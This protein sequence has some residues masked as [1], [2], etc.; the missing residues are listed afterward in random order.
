[1]YVLIHCLLKFLNYFLYL[2]IY[3]YDILLNFNKDL[4]DENG[5]PGG[6]LFPFALYL[7]ELQRK[8]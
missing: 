4:V 2:M 6:D 1:M 7:D 5:N 8:N 3:I